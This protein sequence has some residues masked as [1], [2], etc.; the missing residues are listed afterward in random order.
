MAPGLPVSR[1]GVEEKSLHCPSSISTFGCAMFCIL[2]RQKFE[3][4]ERE[5]GGGVAEWRSRD[6]I[7][8]Q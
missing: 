5:E 3:L 2:L 7:W 1:R 8:A 4:V 6:I